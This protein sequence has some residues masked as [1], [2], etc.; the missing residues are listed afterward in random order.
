MQTL[1]STAVSILGGWTKTA[2]T[3]RAA[4]EDCERAALKEREA[5]D[6]CSG[7]STEVRTLGANMSGCYCCPTFFSSTIASEVLRFNGDVREH[8]K[9]NSGTL[10]DYLV[11]SVRLGPVNEV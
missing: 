3:S 11:Q 7:C 10:V 6:R 4:L 8:A 2:A 5:I 1:F 9:A